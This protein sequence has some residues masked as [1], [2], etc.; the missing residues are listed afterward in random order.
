VIQELR[1]RVRDPLEECG[2]GL[3]DGDDYG[4]V[5]TTGARTSNVAMSAFG[6]LERS[7]LIATTAFAARLSCSDVLRLAR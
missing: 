2:D 7:R 3:E 4:A 6:V 5:G 1:S